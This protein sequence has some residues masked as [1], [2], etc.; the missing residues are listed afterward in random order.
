[1]SLVTSFSKSFE[2]VM[3]ARLLDHLHK[4]NIISREQDGFRTV[5][6]MENTT[7]KLINEV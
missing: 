7:Y 5:L 4:N 3:Q 1:M 2:K 6:A